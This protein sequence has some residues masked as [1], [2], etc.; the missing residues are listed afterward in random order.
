MTKLLELRTKRDTY[1]STA[2]R[3]ISGAMAEGRET[4]T[5]KEQS[6]VDGLKE[7]AAAI[8]ATIQQFDSIRDLRDG[9]DTRTSWA[10]EQTRGL[11]VKDDSLS[12]AR[13]VRAVA[14][15][16]G[17]PDRA[18]N[19]AEKIY[20]D[21]GVA[22]A[23]AAGSATAGG[24]M[25]PEQYNADLIE[26]LRAASVVRKLG[27][28]VYPMNGTTTL[29]KITSGSAATYIGENENISMTDVRFGLVKATAKKLA[30]LIPISNEL[31]RFASPQ[32]DTVVREDLVAAIAEAEDQNFLRSDGT[33]AAPKGLRYWAPAANRLTVNATVNV[34]NVRRDTS[35]LMLQL[36]NANVRMRRPGWIMSPRT[37]VYLMDLTDGQGNKVFPEMESGR[38]RGFPFAWTT[39]VPNNLAVTGTNESE[40]YFA[41]FADVV[42]AES[43]G[44][45]IDVSTE[46]AYHD[47]NGVVSAFSKDQT[48]I[49]VIA[50][51]DLVLR[52]SESVAVLT[53]VDWF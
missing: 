12:L 47:G 29:P 27:A 11:Q 34:D 18:A 22:K 52:H 1:L 32:A 53:D 43:P 8:A 2:N 45:I 48:V 7:K 25:V 51:H 13:F 4:L 19:F 23:L 33:G 24:F 10:P 39:S 36:M 31:I 16:K 42:I 49:R 14:A 44:L 5:A 37:M 28:L 46:A 50:Q 21:S 20:G 35:R 40:I 41:D 9:D 26:Y 17:D 38:F 15:G 6:D 30:A 3:I